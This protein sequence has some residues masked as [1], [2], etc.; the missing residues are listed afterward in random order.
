MTVT[1]AMADLYD[2]VTAVPEQTLTTCF[3]E[4]EVVPATAVVIAGGD[5]PLPADRVVVE[6]H[7]ADYGRSRSHA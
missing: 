4:S 3:F 6:P 2:M 5:R 1:A 7:F